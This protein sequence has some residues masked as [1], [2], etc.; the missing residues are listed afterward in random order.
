KFLPSFAAGV[1]GPGLHGRIDLA[2]YAVGLKEGTN[3]FI[4][5]H[6][7]FSN[8]AGTQFVGEVP[9]STKA[10]RLVPFER[11]EDTTYAVL[12]GDST[13]RV[14][15]D[16][17]FLPV[18]VATPY[19]STAL[20]GINYVQSI[21]VMYLAHPN[22]PPRKL[23]HSGELAWAISTVATNPTNAV[24]AAPTVTAAGSGDGKTYSYRVST[25]ING[26][27][28]MASPIGRVFNA[29]DLNKDAQQNTVTWTAPSGPAPDEYRVY[30]LRGGIWAYIGFTSGA[31]TLL[32]DNIDPDT[33]VSVREGAALFAGANNYP[34]RVTIA[35]QRLIWAASNNS[36]E[37]IWGSVTGDYENYTRGMILKASDRIILDVSGE[38]LNRV[39]GLV[40][41]QKLIAL[42]GSGEYGIGG[43]EGVLAAT[44][45]KQQ[46]YG[47]NGSSGLR[48]MV[49][50]ESIIYA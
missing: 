16:G 37:T 8:R 30:R 41:L 13:M 19:P 6:G 18:T 9:D 32:D 46:R 15:R 24:P 48:P 12:F 26:I 35:Q 34:S 21:D 42:T 22:Y 33:A 47:A 50:G 7:G 20:G 27:E 40:Y 14:I 28:G 44:E 4:H 31:L 23:L 45:P 11:D 36:P 43:D 1:L 38:K 10:H 49:I 29:N 5:A 39:R 3:I 25:V 17:A 2:K